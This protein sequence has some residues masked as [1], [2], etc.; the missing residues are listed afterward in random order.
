MV[1][2]YVSVSRRFHKKNTEKRDG[3]YFLEADAPKVGVFEFE[4]ISI[5]IYIL[6][7]P[8]LALLSYI[9]FRI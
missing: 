7:Y 5:Q 4:L 1:Q 9:I 6:S 3:G 2:T 8:E